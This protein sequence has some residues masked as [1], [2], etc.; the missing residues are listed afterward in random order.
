MSLRNTSEQYGLIAVV[1]HWIVALALIGLFALGLWMVG[2]DYY[3][4]WYRDGPWWH[5]SI[6][7]M[8]GAVMIVRLLFRWWGPT[9]VP[10]KSLKR[11]ERHMASI[12]HGLLYLLV[13]T[14]VVSGYLISTADGQPIEVF[15]WFN[16]PSLISGIE[17]QEDIAGEVHEYLAWFMIVLASVH[18]LAALKHHFID[19]DR[20]LL[21]MLG[22]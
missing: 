17:N 9:P 14:I 22:R 21:K 1:L 10:E 19:G 6:G 8:V 15:N 20:T 4:P 2:L 3:S 5:R 7:L 12:T 13:F 18:A 16:L 11:Y